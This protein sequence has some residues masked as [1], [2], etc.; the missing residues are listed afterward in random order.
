M[1]QKFRLV[2]YYNLRR[3]DIYIDIY[4][5]IHIYIIGYYIY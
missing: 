1:A 5:D 2:K 3:Y 4:T